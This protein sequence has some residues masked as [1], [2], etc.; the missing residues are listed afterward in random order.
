MSK[1]SWSRRRNLVHSNPYIKP[2]LW[3]EFSTP[4]QKH[5]QTHLKVKIPP[6]FIFSAKREIRKKEKKK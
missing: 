1:S 5:T 2:P 6:L 3:V 4:K